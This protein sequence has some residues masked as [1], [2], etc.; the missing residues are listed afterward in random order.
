MAWS[1]FG[2]VDKTE[3]EITESTTD[4]VVSDIQDR[5]N[6]NAPDESAT[7]NNAEFETITFG[8]YQGEAIEWIV[9]DTDAD[10][11]LFVLSK[12]ALDV[13]PYDTTLTDVTWETCTL[14]QWLNSDFYN[15]AFSSEEQSRIILSTITNPD[16]TEYGLNTPGG[17]DTQDY[18]F[19]LSFDEA[20]EYLD[21][22]NKTNSRCEPTEYAI[23]QN[24][25]LFEDSIYCHWWLRSPGRDNR[26]ATNISYDGYPETYTG[27][28]APLYGVRPAMW[29]TP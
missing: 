29:I 24:I 27:T 10:G 17:N 16:M 4:A 21:A 1:V 23:S 15:A 25:F 3:P 11:N 7:E 14:R 22:L 18:I 8:T 12:Y 26:C 5:M 6:E 20:V 13:I 9:L 2:C 28:E 19:C